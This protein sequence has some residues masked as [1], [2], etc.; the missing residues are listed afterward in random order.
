MYDYRKLTDQERSE[1][2]QQRKGLGYPPHSP[3]RFV[4]AA[5]HYLFTAACFEHKPLMGAPA[6]RQTL[7]DGLF[8]H[9]VGAG[10]RIDA[11]VIL[12]NHYHLLVQ[13]AAR[14]S[15]S[16][17]FRRVHG[18][19]AFQ[20]NGE[21]GV[22]GRKVWCSFSD[23]A[24]RSERHYYATVNYIHFNAVKHG[25]VASPYDWQPS[26]VGWYKENYGRELLREL[27]VT[28]PVG[29]YGEAWDA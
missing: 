29:R 4:W 20:W 16:E 1:V 2:L 15:V 23:R 19:L 13:L 28:Y 11:W 18:R 26:S 9:F 8:E 5:S 14:D 24:I 17:I 6:R 12:P 3:P 22:R 21:D 10:H 25:Y 7:L 27:W